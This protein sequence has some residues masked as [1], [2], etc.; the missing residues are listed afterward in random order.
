MLACGVLAGPGRL[1]RLRP[2]LLLRLALRLLPLHAGLF[3]RFLELGLLLSLLPGVF[4][5][6]RLQRFLA[7]GLLLLLAGLLLGKLPLL[8]FSFLRGLAF[9]FQ[10]ARFLFL[11]PRKSFAL[12]RRAV[13]EFPLAPKIDLDGPAAPLVNLHHLHGLAAR[14]ADFPRHGGVLGHRSAVPV[15]A[16]QKRQQFL[17]G[18]VRHGL[19]G[20]L[21][22]VPGALELVHQVLHRHLEVLGKFGDSQISHFP[23][24]PPAPARQTTAPAPP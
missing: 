10:P 5:G 12:Q 19:A 4:L 7:F 13:H 23:P 21:E 11:A 18:H 14:N 17:A 20:V 22:A 6:L 15:T 16:A 2:A 8:L 1:G 24:A 3:L 9:L